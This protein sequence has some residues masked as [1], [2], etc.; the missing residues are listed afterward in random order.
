MSY[1]YLY[2]YNTILSLHVCINI[3]PYFYKLS[4]WLFTYI[5]II[6]IIIINQLL[7]L[8]LINYYYY[9]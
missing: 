3:I 2:Q 4:N 9:Y 5:I 1:V 7:L 8:L 6:I